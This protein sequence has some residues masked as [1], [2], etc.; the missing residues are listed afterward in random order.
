[1]GINKDRSPSLSLR[2][3]KVALPGPSL[4]DRRAEYPNQTIYTTG[5]D[6]LPVP[7]LYCINQES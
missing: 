4:L 5:R 7:F 3:G 2:A 6:V 1:M